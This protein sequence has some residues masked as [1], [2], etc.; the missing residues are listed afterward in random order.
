MPAIRKVNSPLGDPD[1]GLHGGAKSVAT[2]HGSPKAMI[3]FTR[4]N[5]CN[6]VW[7]EVPGRIEC[8]DMVLR[9]TSGACKLVMPEARVRRSRC[10]EFTTHMVSAVGEAF[11]NVV[12]H[13]YAG[14]EPGSVQVQIENCRG[15]M[16]VT[17]KNTGMSFDP[18]QAVAPNL[19]ALPESGLGVFI[20]RSFVDE[21]TYLSGSAGSPNVLTLFKRLDENAERDINTSRLAQSKTGKALVDK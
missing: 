2:S 4:A 15:W 14:R 13:G 18:A 11:N 10:G 16:R 5:G 21:V 9:T 6:V 17:I 12:L 1:R 8:R 20:M 3:E 19:D 7:L